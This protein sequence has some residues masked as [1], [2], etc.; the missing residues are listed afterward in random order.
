MSANRIIAVIAV[1]AFALAGW[2]AAVLVI[3]LDVL[4]DGVLRRIEQLQDETDRAAGLRRL[5]GYQVDS[6]RNAGA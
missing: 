5:D 6:T 3:A 4:T 2:P 1:L